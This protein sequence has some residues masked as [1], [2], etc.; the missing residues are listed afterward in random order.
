VAFRE[1]GITPFRGLRNATEGVPYRA[2][3]ALPDPALE[4]SPILRGELPGLATF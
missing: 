2:L 3:I 4:F 1:L